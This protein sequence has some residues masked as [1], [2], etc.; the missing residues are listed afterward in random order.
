MACLCL[1]DPLT[2]GC[3]CIPKGV[4]SSGWNSPGR[5]A[6]ACMDGAPALTRVVVSSGLNLIYPFFSW[7]WG[8]KSEHLS[9]FRRAVHFVLLTLVWL[10]FPSSGM[11]GPLWVW[12]VCNLEYPLFT[13]FWYYLLWKMS[14]SP[15]SECCWRCSSNMPLATNFQVK[16]ATLITTFWALSL[17]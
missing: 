6:S 4:P 11:A 3:C 5:T 1:L 2:A 15:P 9:S 13:L 16:Y 8:P 7:T 14:S 17:K 10:S 12:Q